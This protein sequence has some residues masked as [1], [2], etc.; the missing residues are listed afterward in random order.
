[1]MDRNA[2]VQKMEAQLKEWKADLDKLA[3][4]AEGL[5]ADARIEFDRKMADLRDKYETAQ[6]RFK[7]VTSASTDAF[8]SMKKSFDATVQE[9]TSALAKVRESFKQEA[10]GATS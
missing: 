6:A 1:M 5:E 7:T 2:Y 8:E 9:F 3:A 10:A 4:R